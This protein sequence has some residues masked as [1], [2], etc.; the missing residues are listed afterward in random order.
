MTTVTNV[1]DQKSW[2]AIMESAELTQTAV[3][4]IGPGE[5]SGPMH[6]EHPASE[7]VL[8]LVEGRLQAEIGDRSFTMR[9]GDAVIVKREIPH[10][11]TND[12]PQP[13]LTFNVYS[14]PAY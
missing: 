12:G 10:R 2:F 3:M 11:F 7:Q 4:T 1:R 13:A 14:P 8:Y 5:S 9:A 6:N